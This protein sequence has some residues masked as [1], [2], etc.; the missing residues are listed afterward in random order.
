MVDEWGEWNPQVRSA[1]M[2]LFLARP[3]RAMSLLEAVQGG[4][5]TKTDLSPNQIEL[6]RGHRDARVKKLAAEV[7]P[8]EKKESRESVVARYQKAINM[9]GD[10]EK[11]RLKYEM[12]CISCHRYGDKGFVVGPDV[13]T[14][15]AAGK[16][17]I[18]GNLFDPNKEVAPQ[19]QTYAFTP[20]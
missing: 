8:V 3:D 1:A 16:E 19:F 10:A 11:G 12:V 20:Q 7:Y 2:D 6:L 5:I 14:F 17:S 4:K 9:K 13:V 18:L 15:K